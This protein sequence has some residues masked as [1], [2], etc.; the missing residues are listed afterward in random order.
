MK[1][2]IFTTITIFLFCVL[3]L[4]GCSFISH[5]GDT[6]NVIVDISGDSKYSEAQLNDA[7]NLIKKEFI[8]YTDCKLIKLE[9]VEDTE[10]GVIFT[11][12]F[13]TGRKS[14]NEGFDQNEYY[15]GWTW[16]L[17]LHNGVWV[18]VNHGYA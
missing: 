7:V 17:E 18:E 6:S 10:N 13:E 9:F 3:V 16:A 5:S 4:C 8:S 1:K 12:E 15:T 2:A 14:S 11:G